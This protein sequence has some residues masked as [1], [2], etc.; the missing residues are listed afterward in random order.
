M[1]HQLDPPGRG[2]FTDRQREYLLSGGEGAEGSADRRLRHSIRENARAAI[3]DLQLLWYLSE[4][5]KQTMAKPLTD[6][7]GFDAVPDWYAE[8]DVMDQ[9][10]ISIIENVDSDEAVGFHMDRGFVDLVSL[11]AY[12]YG[13]KTFRGTVQRGLNEGVMIA[14]LQMN[15]R[16]LDAYRVELSPVD[17][18]DLA[19]ELAAGL[20]DADAE[21]LAERL[22]D[23]L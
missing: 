3:A 2:I 16:D 21:E 4:R 17:N 22:E 1:E 6:Y 10:E 7:Y 18:T 15:R 13:P 23:G 12:L 11:Y 8:S 20:E 5:D 14:A 19:E 9:E